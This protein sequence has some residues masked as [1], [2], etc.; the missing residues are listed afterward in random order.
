MASLVML[1]GIG[2]YIA[3]LN[4]FNLWAA[5]MCIFNKLCLH[6]CKR[7]PLPFTEL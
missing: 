4:C 2:Y 6:S 5:I 1:D 7:I 3:Y